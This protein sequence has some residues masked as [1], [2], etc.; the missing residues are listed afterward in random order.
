MDRGQSRIWAAS[1][2]AAVLAAAGGAWAQP[3]APP[4]NP[5]SIAAAITAGHLLL[6][7][8]GR[9]EH[10]DQTKTATLKDDA[11]AYTVRTQLGL[12]TGAWHD[13]K[14][15]LEFQ[16]VSHLGPED[17]AVNPPGATTPPL[18]GAAKARYP[19][20]NDPDETELNRLQLAWSPVKEFTA[21]VGRQR[22]L[23]DDQRFVGNVGW[24]QNEQTF[25]AAR[26]EFAVQGFSGTYVYL[27]RVNRVLGPS[28]NWKSDSHLMN[29][30]YAAAPQLKLEGFVYALDFSNSVINNSITSGARATGKAPLGPLQLAYGATWAEQQDYHRGA[31]PRFSLPYW[32]VNLAASWK[33]LTGKVDYEVLD[34]NGV[35]GFATPLAT[36]HGFN[37]WADAW[38][39]PGGN[40]S[41]VDGIKD[42]SGSLAW[43]PPIKARYVFNPELTAI[44]HDFHDEK[45]GAALAHEVDV[46][47]AAAFTKQ[48]TGLVKFAQFQRNGV[49]PV[50]TATPPPSRTKVWIGFEYKL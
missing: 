30:T 9:W 46:L 13:V 31:N 4:E 27:D 50:G 1:A 14:A 47:A 34:G 16:N 17:Y 24:R 40:K 42:L 3:T 23:I 38:A 35:R 22:I 49:V 45:T 25:D 12:E 29:L 6:D 41:F 36:T 15:L 11:D 26:A 8:R 20:V 32:D 37:G 48:L 21:T 18:N 10:V 28:S 39:A 2:G 19:V 44:Y 43:R 7:V 5:D 33:M